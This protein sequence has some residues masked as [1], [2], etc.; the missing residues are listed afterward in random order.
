MSRRIRQGSLLTAMLLASSVGAQEVDPDDDFDLGLDEFVVIDA[1]GSIAGSDDNFTGNPLGGLFKNWPE[2]LVIAPIPG[3]GTELG[4][5]LKL[6]G[7]YFLDNEPDDEGNE[8]PS[9]I[10]GFGM[11]AENG[12]WALGAGTYLHLLDDRMRLK[13]GLGYLDVNYRFWGVGNEAGDRGLSVDIN[14]TAPMGY[15]SAT[16]RIWSKLYVG[17]GYL[18]AQTETSVDFGLPLPPNFPPVAFDI[19]LGAVEFPLQFDTRDHEQFP[20]KGWLVE[21]RVFLYR[22]DVGSSFDAETWALDVNRFLPVRKTDVLALR[23]VLRDTSG[24]APFFLLASFG[25]RKDLRGYDVGRY[26][27]SSMFAVQGEYRWQATDRWILTGFAGVGEVAPNLSDFGENLLPAAGA[28]VR[29]VISRKHRVG[30]AFDIGVGKDG[31]E[32]Y[33]GIGEAF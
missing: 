9:I 30:I 16:W 14:Q 32:Y 7:G 25:G 28:G 19:D 18:N 13:A 3:R 20:R 27:D 6:L 24:D 26:R 1:T 29:F 15:A 4:W 5:N 12:S 2:D 33:V 22:E 31:A 10:G 8:K 23:G 17:L 11:I 21:G